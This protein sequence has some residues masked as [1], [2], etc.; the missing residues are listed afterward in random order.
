VRFLQWAL[1]RLG[2]RWDGFRRVRRQVC[3][4]LHK[5]L[6]GLQLEGVSEYQR[7]LVNSE[8][9]WKE[10]DALCRISI[11]RFYRDQGVFQRLERELLPRLEDRALARGEQRLRIWSAGCACGEEAYTL[12]LLRRFSS[13]PTRCEA[14]IVATDVDTHLLA[15]ARRACYPP[16]SLRELPK[17]WQ[18][19][20]DSQGDERCLKPEYRAP[21]SFVVQ[22]IRTQTA[23]GPFDLI[24]CRN[25]VFTYFATKVQTEVARR[26]ER[27]LVCGG[28]LLLGAHESMPEP[29]PMLETAYPWLYWRRQDGPG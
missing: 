9:E 5:R 28:A 1:P 3:K 19:A 23:D 21:V 29:L 11:S 27:S 12:V 7:L 16:S 18:P 17:A 20:F 26:L 10:L 6:R 14:D 25:L 4:R 15:R 13:V 22:D 8:R 2:L 24:L